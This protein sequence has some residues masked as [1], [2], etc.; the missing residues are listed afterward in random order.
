MFEI[1]RSDG[2]GNMMNNVELKWDSEQDILDS[3]AVQKVTYQRGKGPISAEL[4]DTVN[5][6]TGHFV[7]KFNDYG[8]ADTANWTIYHYDQLGGNLIDSVNSNTSIDIGDEQ[9]ISQWGMSVQVRQ[10]NYPCTHGSYNC[11]FRERIALPISASME[12]TDTTQKWL[13]GV[14]HN[15]GMTPLNWLMSGTFNPGFGQADPNDSIY[16]AGCY[17]SNF[18]DPDNLFTELIDGIIAP[19]DIARY[20]ECEYSPIGTPGSP[21]ASV[22]IQG[23][24]TN[25]DLPTVYHPSVDIVI[26]S[27]KSK[28]TRCAV[29][30][31]NS[32]ENTSINGGKPGMLRQSPSIDKEGRQPGDTGYNDAEAGRNGTQPEGMGWFP[33]YAI[34]VET[35]RRLNMAYCE[36]STMVN[37]NGTD[38]QWNPTENLL[39]PDGTPVLGGQHTIYV[40]G[41]EKFNMPNYDEGDFIY[42]NLSAEESSEFRAVYGNLSWVMQPLLEVGENLNSSDVRIKARINKEFKSRTLS[43]LNDSRPMFEWDVVPYEDVSVDESITTTKEVLVNIYPNPT[44]NKF[45]AS[46]KNISVEQ[47]KIY[48]LN[49][50]MVN[51]TSV[52]KNSTNK[53]IDVSH[54]NSGIY[55]VQI[56]E[57]V[58]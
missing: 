46:W 15:N 16:N 1:T 32:D 42:N 53:V 20:N 54:L 45:T 8:L 35:G 28:W 7:L 55:F 50:K 52:N 48:S 21:I 12:F 22:N 11:P 26:T 2:E 39:E 51:L 38:M 14:K 58:R 17:K 30:E 36:N 41:G 3:N 19:G 56:G 18:N 23:S 6:A 27:D 9:I 10:E 40:F 25:I 24:Y 13:T 57:K 44:N 4:V 47:I 43:D 33:G 5:H 49:G 29:I 34:D 37:D 31:L